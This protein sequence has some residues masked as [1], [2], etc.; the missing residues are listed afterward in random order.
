VEK[1]T[2]KIKLKNT[3]NQKENQTGE[4]LKGANQPNK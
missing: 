3:K 2:R 4:Q 1:N